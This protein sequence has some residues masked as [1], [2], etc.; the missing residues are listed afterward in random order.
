[1]VLWLEFDANRSSGAN[2]S[3]DC[4]R[5]TKRRA[6]QRN[7]TSGCLLP[8]GFIPRSLGYRCFTWAA[9]N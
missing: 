4:N 3:D 6:S 9:I 2:C 7:G 5:V 1:M 8:P